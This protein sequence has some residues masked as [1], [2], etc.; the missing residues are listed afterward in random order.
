M[1]AKVYLHGSKEHNYFIGEELGL[2]GKALENFTY[3]CYEVEIGLEV[4]KKTGDS[5]I[6]SVDGSPISTE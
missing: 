3:A 4:D 6:I 1:F 5:K 2:K